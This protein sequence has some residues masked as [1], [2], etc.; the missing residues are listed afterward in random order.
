MP[1]VD[2]A[3]NVLAFPRGVFCTELNVKDTLADGN[4]VLI[5]P[6]TCVHFIVPLHAPTLVQGDNVG[7]FGFVCRAIGHNHCCAIA[8][9]TTILTE[10]LCGQIR[11]DAKLFES[12]LLSLIHI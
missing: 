2:L 12:K 11:S 6:M 3:E 9:P 5:C 4:V 1:I 10:T 8:M 7:G